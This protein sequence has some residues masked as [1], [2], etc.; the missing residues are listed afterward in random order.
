MIA[1]A[2]ETGAEVLPD[3]PQLN[4][5]LAPTARTLEAFAL[6]QG[7]KAGVRRSTQF[8]DFL[9][10]TL[11]FIA[12][13]QTFCNYA[14]LLPATPRP[15][16]PGRRHRHLA[17]VH[18]H[19]RRADRPLQRDQTPRTARTARPPR[20]R[21]GPVSATDNNF[22]HANPYPYTASPGQHPASARPATRSTS[23]TRS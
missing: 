6:N 20:P 16:A 1:S 17:A 23:R 2:F 13:A 10:P 11:R 7:V 9:T 5:Q 19:V 12:P 15:A 8:F 3:A 21:A 18:R 4:A 14:S 22:L